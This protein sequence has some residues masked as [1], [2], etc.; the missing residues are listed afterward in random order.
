MCVI[1][2][3]DHLNHVCEQYERV[4]GGLQETVLTLG[5]LAGGAAAD[6]TVTRTGSNVTVED[7][8]IKSDIP[9]PPTD[10]LGWEHGVWA[11]ATL[12]IDQS[13]GINGTELEAVVARTMA[14][15]ETV[16]QIEFDRTPPVRV[17][18]QQQQ[19]NES[20]EMTY[21]EANRTLLNAQYETLFLIGSYRR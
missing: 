20:G 14:R 17:I 3:A 15:V 6:D 9:D 13:D 2:S 7:Q 19:R 11:N 21:S 5:I 1:E 12:S 16:R 10:T 8:V 18:F 4:L